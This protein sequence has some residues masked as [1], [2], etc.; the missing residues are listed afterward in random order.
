MK[1]IIQVH[2]YRGDT[3]FVAEAIDLPVVTQG[4]TLDELMQNLKEAVNLQLEGEDVSDFG[5][6][7][8]PSIMASFEVEPEY[9]KV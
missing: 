8:H 4:K 9:A 7:D 2:I 1:K 5:L 3:Q 6:A